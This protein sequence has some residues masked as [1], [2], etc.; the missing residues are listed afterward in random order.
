[1]ISVAVQTDSVIL[2]AFV[3]NRWLIGAVA[4]H[5]AISFAVSSAIGLPYE[6]G[7]IRTLI[8]LC[9]TLIPF[10]LFVL[11]VWRVVYMVRKVR[12]D[13]PAAWLIGDIKATVL[14]ANR[15]VGGTVTLLAMAFFLNTFS[16]M[17]EAIPAINPFSWDDAFVQA[18]RILFAGYDAYVAM[19]PVFGHPYA[20][21]LFNLAYGGWLILMYFAV[22]VACFTYV[23]PAA[24]NSFLVAFVLTWGVGGNLL[25]TIFASVGPVFYAPLG[26]GETFVPLMDYLRSMHMVSPN[27]SLNVQDQLWAGYA[28]GNPMAGISAFPSM[29]VASS[30]LLMIYAF[31]YARLAGILMAV[32]LS[33]IMIGS[34][35]LGWHY[36]VDGIAGA[37]IAWVAW[38]IGVRLTKSTAA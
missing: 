14:D 19:L 18:D 33:L 36:A 13:K 32:F 35:V 17:K 15:M 38:K 25:A 30:T 5:A 23:N 11:L 27:L 24:R 6:N 29:H 21:T 4:L 26:L 12:P 1:M 20:L 22:F 10:F 31:S 34:V 8:T 37:L 7:V 3:A 28:S 2:R 9:G 16:Y